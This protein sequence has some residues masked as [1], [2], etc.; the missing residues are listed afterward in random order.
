[1]SKEFSANNLVSL[2]VKI[3]THVNN[4]IALLQIGRLSSTL[5]L[6]LGGLSDEGGL[7]PES[8]FIPRIH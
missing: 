7:A 1:M 2:K 6:G 4:F 3:L 8:P 5:A